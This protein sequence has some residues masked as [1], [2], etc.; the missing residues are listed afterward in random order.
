MARDVL[1]NSSPERP[2]PPTHV[3]FGP[4]RDGLRIGENG[5]AGA[6]AGKWEGGRRMIVGVVVVVVDGRSG[7]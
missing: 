1:S 5:I 7:E 3:R 2:Y 6:I 4:L